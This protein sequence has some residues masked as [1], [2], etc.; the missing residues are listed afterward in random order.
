MAQIETK[1]EQLHQDQPC[2][3]FLTTHY[4]AEVVNPTSTY[5]VLMTVEH[6]CPNPPKGFDMGISP[7][8]DTIAYF[9][10]VGI[11]DVARR[12]CEMNG[13]TTIYGR[14]TRLVIDLNRLEGDDDL[15]VENEYYGI[16]LPAN[17]NMSDEEKERRVREYYRPYHATLDAHVKRLQQIHPQP[18]FFS[19]H[20]YPRH[21]RGL[22]E[23]YPWD[24]ACLYNKDNRMAQIFMDHIRTEYP[25]VCV[26][27]NQPYD[28]REYQ[29]GSVY[30]HGELNNLPYLVIEVAIDRM[31][32]PEDTEYWAKMIHECLTKSIQILCAEE[33]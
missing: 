13:A 24:F 9:Y 26:G 5:P 8:D 16:E 29:T 11:P 18:L 28:L 3:E 25:D 14:T 19:L 20:S 32:T 6:A 21:E 7:Q 4:M 22:D 27:D 15:I 23:P 33:A 10:D 1:T 31:Q 17:T 30:Q 2:K 12:V